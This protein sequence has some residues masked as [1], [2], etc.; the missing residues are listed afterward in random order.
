MEIEDYVNIYLM[1]NNFCMMNYDLN[2]YR[3]VSLWRHRYR[4]RHLISNISIEPIRTFLRSKFGYLANF[5]PIRDYWK[6]LVAM[7]QTSR[8][9]QPLLTSVP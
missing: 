5:M 9:E 6:M 3:T 7:M 2:R 1:I 8:C 4:Y